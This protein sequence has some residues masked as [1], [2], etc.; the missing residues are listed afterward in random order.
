[1]GVVFAVIAF[2]LVDLQALERGRYAALGEHQ[3]L[4][5]VT[6]PAD[7]GAIFDRNGNDLAVSVDV[8]SVWADPRVI[9]RPAEYAAKL[10]PVVGV[11]E[12]EL[13]ARLSQ[14]NLAFV[15]IARK[16]TDDVV[17]G[18]RALKLPG[19][20]FVAETKRFYPKGDLA[21]PVL[22]LVGLD[23]NGLAG[24][25]SGYEKQLAGRAGRMVVERDPAGLDL[26]NGERRGTAPQRGT[27]L[28]L[29]LDQSLQYA[30]ERE[31]VAAVDQHNAVGGM[32]LVADT[33]TGDILA[34][35]TVDGA[36]RDQPVRPALAS[37]HNRPITDVFEPGSTNK[38]ITVAGAIEEGLV[39]SDTVLDVPN[40]IRV[41]DKQFD[42]VESHAPKLSVADILRESSNVGAI[43]IAHLLGKE[44]FDRYQRAF[45]F[46]SLSGVR[47][48]GES[49][50]ILLPVNQ[51]NNTSLYSIPIGNG[52]AVTALQ[53]LDA[54]MT[55]ANHGDAR[56]PRL[57]RATI[58]SEGNEHPVPLVPTHRVG[59]EA[60]AA[61]M[62][63]MLEQVVSP[64]G[65]GAKAA[66]AGYRVAGKTGTARKPPY[67]HP[68]FKY[69]ASFVG[70]APADA[71]AL[72]AIVVIDAPSSS[73]IFAS[74]VA[75]PV[76]SRIMSYALGVEHVPPSGP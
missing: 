59:S 62:T 55:F 12:A 41:D 37:E 27:D 36:V 69:V 40:S 31:L 42:D 18:V 67:E 6:V 50:G 56:A 33:R 60:T 45:G 21:A 3:R 65:T 5:T 32:A 61:E 23:N 68:P 25:E 19:V 13:E 73:S 58:D 24:V 39:H 29:T 49:P 57:V 28:V 11:D 8:K 52:I 72:A 4:R 14:R 63:G 75:A 76:F 43:K 38:V 35:A 9:E 22:G 16:V 74:E 20:H 15:Y 53:M 7:R 34:M 66:I 17:R 51:Y 46:G 71:P 47:F 1:M 10:A 26:P 30:V 44:R 48:P 64:T 54:Y 2:R 70:F